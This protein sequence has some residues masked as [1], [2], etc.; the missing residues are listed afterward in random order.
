MFIA[1]RDRQYDNIADIEKLENGFHFLN[2][3]RQP[4][5]QVLVDFSLTTTSQNRMT[6]VT[7]IDAKVRQM[8]LS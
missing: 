2:L 6:I 1:E 8:K 7:S 4:C 3:V 5:L